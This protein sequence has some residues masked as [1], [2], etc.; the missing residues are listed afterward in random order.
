MFLTSPAFAEGFFTTSATWEVVN[1][2][3][4]LGHLLQAG[5][6]S[7]PLRK[8]HPTSVLLPGES[9]GQRSLAVYSPRGHKEL[10][11]TEQLNHNNNSGSWPDVP[12][13]YT[14]PL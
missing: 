10:D 13:V 3:E 11:M 5:T 12:H 4:V 6:L 8:W 14:A 7:G 1:L 9:H 2:V